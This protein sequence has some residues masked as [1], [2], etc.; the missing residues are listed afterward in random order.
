M[1]LQAARF[2]ASVDLRNEAAFS[3]PSVPGS[4]GF[5]AVDDRVLFWRATIYC[6]FVLGMAQKFSVNRR[7]GLP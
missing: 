1:S 7:E 6:K 4:T 3:A 2:A 5:Y